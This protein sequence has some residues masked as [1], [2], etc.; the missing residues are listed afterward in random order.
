MNANTAPGTAPNATAAGPHP[1]ATREAWLQEAISRLRPWFAV[2]G[3]TVPPCQVSCGFASSGV[4]SGH[5][6]QCWSRRSSPGG[7]NQVFI[8]PALTDVVE[9]LDTLVHELVHAVDD[10]EHK[11][12][13]EFKKIALAMGLKGPMRS[14]GAGPELKAQ[15]QQLA[16]DLAA[17]LGPYPHEGLNVPRKA[18]SRSPRPRARCKACGFTVP[19]LKKFLHVGPPLCPVH[20]AAMDPLGDWDE[21]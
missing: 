9:V 3:Y 16:A 6:G 1:H 14:A 12:G 8:S 4:R 18:A 5:I 2:K 7:I 15:L 17:H 10:C 11:H 13:P 19:M 20:K 21:L